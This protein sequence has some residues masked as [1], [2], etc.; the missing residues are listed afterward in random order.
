MMLSSE[1]ARSIAREIASLPPLPDSIGAIRRISDD[2]DS[3]IIDLIEVVEGDPMLTANLLR[4]A[5]SPFYGQGG[6]IKRIA[7]AVSLFGMTTVLGFALACTARD[8]VSRVDL[9]PY[10]QTPGEL[11]NSAQLRSA[12]IYHWLGSP[13]QRLYRD[14]IVPAAFLDGIGRVVVASL[15]A[16]SG[17]SESFRMAV[18]QGEAIGDVEKRYC[19][20]TSQKIGAEILRHWQL[21]RLM[22]ESL[23]ASDQPFECE[24]SIR[25]HATV[26]AVARQVVN[27][28][29]EIDLTPGDGVEELLAFANLPRQPLEQAVAL[30]VGR[31]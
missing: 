15:L 11:S 14:T 1:R 30:L 3:A 23:A 21:D 17:E 6:R 19:G 10:N 2:P 28:Q 12:L 26:L 31:V 22:S 24:P 25:L 13:R 4:Q 27:D 20:T 18:G 16:R 9:T 8:T 29:A 5:N 7:Q